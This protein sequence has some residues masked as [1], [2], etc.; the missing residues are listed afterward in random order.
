[1]RLNPG[2]GAFFLGISLGSLG[3]HPKP[4]QDSVFRIIAT[5][6][7]FEAPDTVPAGMR[8]IVMENHGTEIHE[9]MLVKLPPETSADDYFVA[10]KRGTLFPKGA[11]DYSGPGLISPG[12]RTELWLKV[13]PGNYVLI[14]WNDGHARKVPPHPFT[15][16]NVLANDNAPK[17]D[18]VVKLI[19]YRFDLEG[20]LRFGT[21]V[22]RVETLGPS[23]HEMD[24]LRLHDGKTVADVTRWRKDDGRGDSPVDA[25]GGVLDSH[26]IHRVVWLRRTFTPGRY[27]LHCEMPVETTAEITKQEINH[28]DLG[29]IREFEIKR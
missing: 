10:V 20:K 2:Y 22:I 26:D 7:G 18:V 23:M 19:D 25:L 17:E 24:L 5:D 8:H 16:T 13:D 6:T 27:L 21:Q 29:M 9:S 4:S 28:A 1:M 12:E 15:V 11:L 14:C 3:C